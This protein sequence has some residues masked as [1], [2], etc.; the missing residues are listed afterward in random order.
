MPFSNY[1][2][3]ALL[4]HVARSDQEAT[5]FSQPAQLWCALHDSDPT[6]VP[7][8]TELTGGSYARQ[9]VFFN[10]PSSGEVTNVDEVLFDLLPSVPTGVTHFSI[11]DASSSGNMLYHD[12]LPEVQIVNS[13]DA[14]RVPAGTLTLRHSTTE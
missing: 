11:W 2:S 12:I 5:S 6:G 9:R 14:I 13:G 4:N 8:A 3:H 10:A 1:L 7:L